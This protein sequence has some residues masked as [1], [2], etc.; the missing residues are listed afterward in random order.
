MEQK[1][2]QTAWV[3]G[4]K[5]VMRLLRE[6]HAL[7]VLAAPGAA[8]QSKGAGAIQVHQH[9]MPSH[10]AHGILIKVIV[11]LTAATAQSTMQLQ[12][13]TMFQI[14]NYVSGILIM[15]D[16]VNLSHAIPLIITR[17]DAQTH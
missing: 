12:H 5:N 2:S 15:E 7:T 6:Q 8:A 13:A 4:K 11:S 10:I 17:Q 3:H 16:I 14:I 9:A 1:A